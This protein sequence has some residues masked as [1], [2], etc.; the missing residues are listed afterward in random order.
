MFSTSNPDSAAIY[1]NQIAVWKQILDQNEKNK[2]E[3]T[4][5]ENRSFSAGADYTSS[6][7][8]RSETSLSI[9]GSVFVEKSAFV[10][11]GFET[12]NTGGATRVE[13]RVRFELGAS[14]KQVL[15]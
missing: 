15:L 13:A 10:E 6:V 4:F 1:D 8:T 7:T 11:A 2:S 14:A 5:I 9:E 12:S 3:A